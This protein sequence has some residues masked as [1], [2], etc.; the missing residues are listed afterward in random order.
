[1]LSLALV[2]TG[3]SSKDDPNAGVYKA[4]SATAFGMEMSADE[5]FED[6]VIIDLENC[7]SKGDVIVKK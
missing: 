5:V 2:M 1:M 7:V 4:V 6:D 3:C